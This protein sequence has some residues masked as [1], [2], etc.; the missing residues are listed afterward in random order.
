MDKLTI[1]HMEIKNTK[2]IHINW[3]ISMC[4]LVEIYLIVIITPPYL[5]I[6]SET[7]SQIA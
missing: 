7:K 6:V 2:K 4:P 1:S 5:V 3:L